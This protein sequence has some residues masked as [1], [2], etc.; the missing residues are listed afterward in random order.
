MGRPRPLHRPPGTRRQLQRRCPQP[1]QPRH[2]HAAHCLQT[3]QHYSAFPGHPAQRVTPDRPLA[4]QAYQETGAH[5]HPAPEHN[6]Q[7]PV[8]SIAPPASQAC[9]KTEAQTP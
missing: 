8:T 9:R 6:A 4:G 1:H 7:R 3:G 5:P 2:Q